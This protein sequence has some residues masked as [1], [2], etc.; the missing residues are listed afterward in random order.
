M[1]QDLAVLRIVEV[2]FEDEDLLNV[3]SKGVR[4]KLGLRTAASFEPSIPREA[5]DESRNQYVSD[6]LLS[7]IS[8]RFSGLVLGL[9]NADAYTPGLNFVFGQAQLGGRAAVVFLE[10]LRPEFYGR[11]GDRSL[12]LERVEKESLH[13]LGHVFGL[14]HCPDRR[15]VMSFSNSIVEVDLK[16]SDFCPR[17]SLLLRRLRA[18]GGVLR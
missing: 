9:V 16:G 15:C 18:A 2:G 17:C 12:F 7:W 1:A 3:V 5:F 10:R 6:A 14:G 11:S 8:R 4:S 13:E